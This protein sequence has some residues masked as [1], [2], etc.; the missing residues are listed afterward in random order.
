MEEEKKV[1]SEDNSSE[2]EVSKNEQESTKMQS[3]E[4][5]NSAPMN[6]IILVVAI[7]VLVA[8]IAGIFFLVNGGGGLDLSNEAQRQE[9]YDSAREEFVNFEGV[10]TLSVEEAGEE[11]SFG[12]DTVNNRIDASAAISLLLGLGGEDIGI[13]SFIVDQAEGR[14]YMQ[15]NGEWYYLVDESLTLDSDS[16]FEGIDEQFDASN[17]TFDGEVD[18][19]T[20]EGMCYQ[21]TNEEG[22]AYF[23]QDSKL[24]VYVEP[25]GDD[26]GSKVSVAYDRGAEISVS[27]DAEELDQDQLT[28]LLL[29]GLE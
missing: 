11:L 4:K 12:I 6:P 28:E 5:A 17:V 16:L 22:T 23:D 27:E 24:P 1:Q 3:V 7:V 26:E 15:I 13:E 14:S 21:L 29:G 10:I 19:P 9:F 8:V 20:G 25:S 18:C 2:K